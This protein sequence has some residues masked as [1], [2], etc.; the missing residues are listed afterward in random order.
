MDKFRSLGAWAGALGLAVAATGCGSGSSTEESSTLTVNGDVAVAYAQ[1]VNTIGL[2][3]TNGAPSAPG[4]D[5]MI[6]E[7]SSPSAIEHN[8]TAQFTQGKGDVGSLDVSYDG[9]KIVF[10]MRCPAANPVTI[11]GQP[12]CTGHWNIW[13]YDMTS[14][15]ITG[16]TFRRLTASN[17][18]DTEP[19]YLP[20]GRGYVFTSNRQ[21]KSSVNQALGYSYFALDEYERER[22]FNLH[23]M[24]ADGNN[25]T[26]ISFNQ[27]HD[28]SP[29]VRP[30]GDI[31]F[32]RWDHV[33][34]RNHFKVFRAKPDGTDMFVLYGAH[35][36]GNS[37]LHPRDM[38]PNGKYKG[39]LTS[40]LMP[41][42]G[43]REGGGLVMID[44][45]NYS[46]NGVPASALVPANGGQK[47]AT[48]VKLNID[49]GLS[50]YGRISSPYP[51]WDGTD[52]VLVSYTPCEVTRY[53][54][55]PGPTPNSPPVAASGAAGNVVSCATL[56]PDEIGRLSEMDR[57]NTDIAAD[58]LKTN[59]PP[60]YSVY[61]FDP[62]QQTQQ[63]V[64]A[65][66]SGFMYVDPVALQ[67]RPEP[68]ATDP[69]PV[70]ASLASQ[71]LGLLEVRSVYDTDNL[72]RMGEGV[73][74]AADLSPGCASS[75]W[76]AG[77]GTTRARCAARAPWWCPSSSTPTSCT[78]PAGHPTRR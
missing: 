15:G 26:Q 66:P 40:D 63:I 22:V 55:V 9:K 65:P 35:S 41:L 24:D 28:R 32:S 1:R 18:D 75:T 64:A 21:T 60:S 58:P 67:S 74:A 48:A 54:T 36:P 62:A 30:N 25:I 56:I 7:K 59:V 13:E 42:S 73:V 72:G 78:C 39:F 77:A 8:V 6:R 34:G 49:K 17:A 14:G 68:N 31:M 20:A 57:L 10:S 50:V 46:E 45:A 44:A 43:T 76:A 53:P 37:F 29:T 5:L 61:M 4:G 38:D 51:L 71:N 11:N 69:T 19:T 70:D 12:A 27:S 3:P 2:N 33:G 23:T 52:R 16:G 47:Q